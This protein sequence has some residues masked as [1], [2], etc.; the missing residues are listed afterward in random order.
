MNAIAS[1]DASTVARRRVRVAEAMLLLAT[2]V[3]GASF[4]LAKEGGAAINAAAGDARALGPI[5]MLAIRFT[6]AAMIVAVAMAASRLRRT[7]IPACLPAAA[8]AVPSDEGVGCAGSDQTGRNACPTRWQTILRGGAIGA[9]LA[10]GTV[11]QHLA[12]D[13]TSEAAAAFLTSLAVIFVPLI[14]WAL[15][16]RRPRPAAWV[17]VAIAVPGVWLMS[18]GG[19][20][21]IGAGEWLGVACAFAFAWHLLAVDRW[22]ASLGAMRACVAQFTMVAI[23]CWPIALVLLARLD[24]FDGF[25][26]SVLASRAF[27]TNVALLVA[28]PTLVSFGLMA[29]FQPRVSPVRAVLI[30]LFEPLFAAAFAWLWNGRGVT[31]GELAG[32]ALILAANAIVELWPRRQDVSWRQDVSS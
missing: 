9:L 16:R 2:A 17:G 11:L 6:I 22:A 12:L 23:V 29:A 30:Y 32:G 31:R 15:L 14:L 21:R 18:G 3:W 20:L 8:L 4:A 25:D 10:V 26:A 5:L 13:R 1:T 28:G 7:G 24:G 19:T 27:L